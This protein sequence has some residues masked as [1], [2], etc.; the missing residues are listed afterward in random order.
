MDHADHVNPV[1]VNA[2]LNF[3]IKEREDKCN[4]KQVPSFHKTLKVS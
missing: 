1:A 2:N 3:E 4:F